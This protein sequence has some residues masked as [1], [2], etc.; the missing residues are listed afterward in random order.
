MRINFSAAFVVLATLFLASTVAA[1]TEWSAFAP[2]GGRFSVSMPGTPTTEKETK[3]SSLGPFTTNLFSVT[4]SGVTY[5][6]GYVDYQPSVRLNVQGEIAATRDK[7]LT[8]VKGTLVAE[9]KVTLDGHPGI[10]FTADIGTTHFVTSRV[11]VVGQRP[12]QL[13]TVTRKGSEQ[14]DTSKFLSS[15]KLKK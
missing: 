13:L 12:Y 11:Y 9:K 1:Q 8:A 4:S 2:E 5:L 14:T 10:E 15:F 3:P 6:V 7:F